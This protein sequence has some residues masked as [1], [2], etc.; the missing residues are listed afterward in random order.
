MAAFLDDIGGSEVDGDP[1]RR[2]SEAQRGERRPYA[3]SRLG[4]RLVR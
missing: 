4:D 3:F 1:F 2:Q